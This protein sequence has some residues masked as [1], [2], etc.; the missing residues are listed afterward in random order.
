M[1]PQIRY[2]SRGF[3]L[4]N[5][6]DGSKY[7]DRLSGEELKPELCELRDDSNEQFKADKVITLTELHEWEYK[8][9]NPFNMCEERT[10]VSKS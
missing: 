5:G 7:M 4:H 1:C 3:F 8:S 2:Q 10:P 9:R 6:F